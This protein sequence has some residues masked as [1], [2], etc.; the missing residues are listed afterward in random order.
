VLAIGDLLLDLTSEEVVHTNAP[1]GHRAF[2]SDRFWISNISAKDAL[3]GFFR[4]SQGARYA[5]LVNK[6]HGGDKSAE[7]TADTIELTFADGVTA[8]EAVSWL[9]GTP[10]NL[11]L[12]N[13]RSSLRIAGGTGVL[14]RADLQETRRR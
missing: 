13:Q 8:V 12:E 11:Q 14:L 3:I 2:E 5:L 7:E 1:R 4:D 9:D 6:Q 10:G